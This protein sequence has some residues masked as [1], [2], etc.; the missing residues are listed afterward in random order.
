MNR[1]PNSSA[2]LVRGRA[3]FRVS[4]TQLLTNSFHRASSALSMQFGAAAM[5]FGMVRPREN[6]GGVSLARGVTRVRIPIRWRNESARRAEL[7]GDRRRQRPPP[8]G[9]Y[10]GATS[11]LA[12]SGGGWEPASVNA[13][14]PRTVV[15]LPATP[16]YLLRPFLAWGVL[17]GGRPRTIRMKHFGHHLPRFLVRDLRRQHQRGSAA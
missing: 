8:F 7:S 2:E 15:E 16:G 5:R 1:H 3:R 11:G 4:S 6:R 9:S 17:P 13:T 14:G 10:R 12:G